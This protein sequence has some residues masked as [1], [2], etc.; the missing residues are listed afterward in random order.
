MIPSNAEGEAAAVSDGYFS[1][2]QPRAP[3]S[4]GRYR[5]NLN[6]VDLQIPLPPYTPPS[7]H[8]LFPPPG[9]SATTTSQAR[10]IPPDATR[11]QIPRSPARAHTNIYNN[12]NSTSSPATP[13]SQRSIQSFATAPDLEKGSLK[14]KLTRSTTYSQLKPFFSRS[15]EP[16][17]GPAL[18]N[19]SARKSMIIAATVLAVIAVILMGLL[20]GLMKWFK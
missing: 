18:S 4:S 3:T 5:P 20:F 13:M 1:G 11:L 14:L 17:D 9:A 16:L 2:A 19:V 7:P 15:S 10:G 8:S 12:S 6:T